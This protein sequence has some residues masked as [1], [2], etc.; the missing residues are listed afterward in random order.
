MTAATADDR[1]GRTARPRRP[2]GTGPIDDPTYLGTEQEWTCSSAPRIVDDA[3]FGF[4]AVGAHRGPH[5]TPQLMV[6]AAGRIW[7]VT[8]AKSLKVHLIRRRPSVSL[9]AWRPETGDAVVVHGDARIL[10]AAHP[11]DLGANLVDALM[12][13]MGL[14]AYVIQHKAEL[15]SV[16]VDL[17]AGRM[18]SVGDRRVVVGILPD[19]CRCLAVPAGTNA[20]LAWTTTD[21]SVTVPVTWDGGSTAR[22]APAART[23]LQDRPTSPAAL[24]IDRSAGTSVSSRSGKLHRGTGRLTGDI[25][26]LDTRSVTTWEGERVQTRMVL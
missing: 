1:A 23:L 7:L 24:S 14:A 18:T 5:L 4:L 8:A 13:S 10:D 3:P 22:V 11:L 15:A 25:V 12:G 19:R 26:T 2:Q 6:S 16:L 20:A 17:A 21:G 9:T